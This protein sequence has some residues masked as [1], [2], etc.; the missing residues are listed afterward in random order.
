MAGLEAMQVEAE[1]GSQKTKVLDAAGP[2]Q[3]KEIRRPVKV[4]VEKRNGDGACSTDNQ[5]R[6]RQ[7]RR[8]LKS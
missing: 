4:I 5:T 7:G 2:T 1:S 6:S 3:H 8:S